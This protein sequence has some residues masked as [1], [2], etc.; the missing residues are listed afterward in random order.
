MERWLFGARTP[1]SR[2]VGLLVGLLLLALAAAPA[3]A[4]P[5]SAQDGEGT[6][7]IG[8]VH[9]TQDAPPVDVYVDGA[10]EIEG[11]A[12]G[13]ASAAI[14][15]G[16][17]ARTI[18]VTAAGSGLEAAFAETELTLDRGAAYLAAN[19][20][21]LAD[22]ELR[23]WRIDLSPVEADG[24]RLRVIHAS[25]DAPAVDVAVAG[26]DVLI[27]GATFDVAPPAVEVPPGTY[28]VEMRPAGSDEVAF[29][30]GDL[31]VPQTTA[32]TVI[33]LGLL[34]DDGALEIATIFTPLN[35]LNPGGLASA[36]TGTAALGGTEH[37][38][39]WPHA[40]LAAAALLLGAAAVRR[41]RRPT[42]QHA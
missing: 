29:A 15:V 31:T 39:G 38:V 42:R 32:C 14:E 12:Y 4:R 22:I 5:A 35:V 6:A 41:A 34:G 25:P 28:D 1:G 11:L 36:G 23:S 7:Q 2:F 30:I 21:L 26:G 27:A 17:G 37:G 10:L 19:V 13:Q 33:A 20:G 24:S 8:F 40:M 18:A 3:L 9:G 16:A